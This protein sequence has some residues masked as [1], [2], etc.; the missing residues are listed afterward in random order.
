MGWT[1]RW[2]TPTTDRAGSRPESRWSAAGNDRDG[3]RREIPSQEPACWRSPQVHGHA[4]LRRIAGRPA[5]ASRMQAQHA[6]HYC[7]CESAR[8]RAEELKRSAAD[9]KKPPEGGFFAGEKE[10]TSSREQQEQRERQQQG[11]QRKPRQLQGQQRKPRQQQE[12][13][14]RQEPV[15]AR[16]LV[17]FCRKQTGQRQQRWRPERETCSFFG[18]LDE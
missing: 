7:R 17:L 14:Q 13:G 12:R 11:R 10:I 16:G 1:L 5:S 8:K 18:V 2:P 9:A 6:Q 3:W 15:R 4:L